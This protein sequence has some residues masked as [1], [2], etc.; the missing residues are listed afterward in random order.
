MR[1]PSSAVWLCWVMN[2][3]PSRR[4][5]R[6]RENRRQDHFAPCTLGLCTALEGAGEVVGLGGDLDIAL[7]ERPDLLAHGRAILDHVGLELDDL[8]VERLEK[9][10]DLFAI[11]PGECLALGLEDVPGNGLEFVGHLLAGLKETGQ[12]S[13]RVLALFFKPGAQ[14]GDLGQQF[15]GLVAFPIQRLAAALAFGAQLM[16]EVA[17]A[18]VALDNLA[19]ETGADL[20]G[21]IGG[22][23]R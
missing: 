14:G 3:S 18:L 6:S 9:R 20:L 10:I 8:F 2:C 5:E 13:V 17:N 22:G 7:V 16:I 12:V 11:L 4:P 1:A 19:F 23:A 21:Q 15:A